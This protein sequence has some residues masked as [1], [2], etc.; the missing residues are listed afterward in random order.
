M[1][2]NLCRC[3]AYAGITEAVLDAQKALARTRSEGRGMNRF[4]YVRPATIAEAVA[5]AAAPGAAY[6]A[7]RHQS[8]GSD[9]GRHRPPAPPGR[10][11]PSARARPRSSTCPTA[12]CG[13]ARCVRNADL[14]HDAG[15]RPAL[16]RGG[17]SAAVRRLGATAQRRD[18]RR[19]SAAAH[20]LRV[21]LRRRQR[22]QQT[23]ARRRLRRARRRDPAARRARLERALHRHPPVRFLRA[24]RGARRGG[25]DRG[26]EPGGARSRWKT[27]TVCPATRRSAKACWSPA[28]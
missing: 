14:A 11:Q 24:A 16:S 5:A 2:G 17:G 4:D 3:G 19:Q 6:L 13:S 22:L 8:A 10:Y 9:E 1:S 18:G 27:S 25:R 26:P 20:A 12:A 15:F 23:R 28:N 21:F 7:G